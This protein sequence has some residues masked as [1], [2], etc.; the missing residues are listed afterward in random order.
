M[1]LPELPAVVV[2]KDGG[3]FIYD[4]TS[5]VFCLPINII[6]VQSDSRNAQQHLCR[7]NCG[8]CMCPRSRSRSPSPSR[9]RARFSRACCSSSH[10]GFPHGIM[11][12]RRP[13]T[14]QRGLC[15]PLCVVAAAMFGGLSF[16]WTRIASQ[17]GMAVGNH[18]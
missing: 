3:Y 10:L 7:L 11:A 1:A 14:K 8:T 17:G 9:P 5:S 16:G 13:V 15:P 2:F 18:I 4:G 12:L 6:V